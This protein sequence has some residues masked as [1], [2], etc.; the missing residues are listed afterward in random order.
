MKTN[1]HSMDITKGL[2]VRELISGYKSVFL[3]PPTETREL[4]LYFM[5]N[6][7]GK[8]GYIVLRN[9]DEVLIIRKDKYAKDSPS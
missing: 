2:K 7:L 3:D 5:E 1:D 6:D 9:N 4:L 8:K